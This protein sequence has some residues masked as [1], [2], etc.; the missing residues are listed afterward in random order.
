MKFC[1]CHIINHENNK[2][3][4]KYPIAMEITRHTVQGKTYEVYIDIPDGLRH[5]AS[6]STRTSAT[7]R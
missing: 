5:L 1:D 6:C 3:K 4:K 2:K 7:W